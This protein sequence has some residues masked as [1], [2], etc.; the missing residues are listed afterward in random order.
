MS[1]L[2]SRFMRGAIAILVCGSFVA[3]PALASS[4]AVVG[5]WTEEDGVFYSQPV[6]TYS[7]ARHSGRKDSEV[8]YGTTRERAHGWT[9]WVGEYHYTRARM[10]HASILCSGVIAD[11][12]RVWGWD[13]TEAISPWVYFNPS[14]CC[15]CGSART[16]YGC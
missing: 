4:P 13:G 11:S 3:A 6:A 12:G 16:Y 7:E 9:T 5:G 8:Y 1:K 14:N 2:V 10:E 15:A